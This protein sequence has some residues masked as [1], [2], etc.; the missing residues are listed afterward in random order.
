[1]TVV[2]NSRCVAKVLAV[3]ALFAVA[4][5]MA[6]PANSTDRDVYIWGDAVY[7]NLAAGESYDF[8]G[9]T[10]ALVAV[11]NN[12]CTVAVNGKPRQLVVARRAL[13]TEIEG[14]RVF[15]ADN[16][17]VADLTET[18]ANRNVHAALTKDALLC[19][20]DPSRPLLDP[21]RYIFPISREDGFEWTMHENSHMFAYLRPVRSHEG[22]DLDLSDARGGEM[23]A[24]VAP[25][26]GVRYEDVIRA[27]DVASA[28]GFTNLSMADG[29]AFL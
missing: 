26:D 4:A 18:Q 28:A 16:R 12:F 10:V 8:A 24:L 14:V 27:M 13:P 17:H 20:S 23:H 2:T 1:M 9:A 7:V 29:A 22:I 21:D 6:G 11:E 19:L 15:V 25:E 3:H 5:S